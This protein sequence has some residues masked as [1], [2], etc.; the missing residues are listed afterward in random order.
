MLKRDSN[1]EVAFTNTILAKVQSAQVF[2]LFLSNNDGCMTNP[3]R[4]TVITKIRNL[5]IGTQD[6]KCLGRDTKHL[7]EIHF[8][9]QMNFSGDIR[10]L[11]PK[12]I[13]PT[14]NCK[15]LANKVVTRI[16]QQSGKQ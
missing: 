2:G 6:T 5:N 8:L 9:L 15:I 13:V 4:A 12:K 1:I 3:K 10:I 7:C 16:P 11:S 14:E